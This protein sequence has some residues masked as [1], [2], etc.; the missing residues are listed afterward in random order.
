M[1]A[2]VRLSSLL[3]EKELSSPKKRTVLD[4]LLTVNCK[5]VKVGPGDSEPVAKATTKSSEQD[6]EDLSPVSCSNHSFALSSSEQ[7]TEDMLETE[8]QVSMTM[9]W[10]MMAI[11]L[12]MQLR[13][14]ENGHEVSV[15]IRCL[16]DQ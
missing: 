4:D 12:S 7:E 6:T 8:V 13:K 5:K 11:A 16:V 15:M 2:G 1:H 14:D 10:L 9:Y 3:S